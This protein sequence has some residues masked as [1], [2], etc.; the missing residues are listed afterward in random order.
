M[1][2]AIGELDERITLQRKSLAD[3][4]AGGA[5]VSWSDV[6]EVWAHV[7]AMSGRERE[8]SMRNEGTAD[9]VVVIRRRE[10]L[11]ADRIVWRGR[12]LNIRNLRDDGPREPYLRIDAEMGAPT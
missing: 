12:Y 4:G 2:Y 11:P 10:L 7:R 9:Y 1:T 8:Q 6:A 3:D 5:T